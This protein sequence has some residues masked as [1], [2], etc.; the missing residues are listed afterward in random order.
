MLP[1]WMQLVY[2]MTLGEFGIGLIVIC[3][4][5][6]LAIVIRKATGGE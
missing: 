6:H 1:Q 4:A 5:L 2:H 3:V